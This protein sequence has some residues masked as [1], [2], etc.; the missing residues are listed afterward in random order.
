MSRIAGVTLELDS[1]LGNLALPRCFVRLP[2]STLEKMAPKIAVPNDPP[3][4]RKKVAPE[5]ATPSDGR[6]GAGELGE[7]ADRDQRGPGD[8]K[9]AVAAG[10]AD[11]EP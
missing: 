10:P 3:I 11:D 6:D 9:R 5:V 8:R 1:P 2:T 4:E 7:D